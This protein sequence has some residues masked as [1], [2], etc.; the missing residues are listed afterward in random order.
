M[1]GGGGGREG[2]SSLKA[3]LLR[4]TDGTRTDVRVRVCVRRADAN[5]NERLLGVRKRRPDGMQLLIAEDLGG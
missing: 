1:D 3:S 5:T 2:I 4:C